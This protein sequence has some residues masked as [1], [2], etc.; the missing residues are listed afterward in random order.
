MHHLNFV[1]IIVGVVTVESVRA[2][3]QQY[4]S[5]G[6]GPK[7]NG[8]CG[9]EVDF[10]CNSQ[11]IVALKY[12]L[13]FNGQ[14]MTDQCNRCVRVSSCE[15]EIDI[16]ARV[17]SSCNEGCDENTIQMDSHH[18]L[19]LGEAD[20]E[21]GR[22][23]VTW[24]FVNCDTNATEPVF[25]SNATLDG[26]YEDVDGGYEDVD[27]ADDDGAVVASL[28][29][30]GSDAS[31]P[32]CPPDLTV[33]AENLPPI[34]EQSLVVKPVVDGGNGSDSNGEAPVEKTVAA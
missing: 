28:D 2:Q 14:Y 34:P 11:P 32:L 3:S 24:E 4:V 22:I 18:A 1:K 15:R 16:I 9:F 20:C 29:C 8:S 17:V 25:L 7:H 33:D 6:G 23:P 21:T 31:N 10:S 26:G 5:I 30:D 19:Q 27:G 13:T 12:D